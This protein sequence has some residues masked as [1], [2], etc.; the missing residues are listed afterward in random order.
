MA[1]S[2]TDTNRMLNRIRL[3]QVALL[4]AVRAHGTLRAAAAEIGMTQPAATKMLRELEGAL[5]SRLYERAGRSL[6][7]T[8]AGAATL[9]H[10]EALRGGLEALGR[11]LAALREG[12]GGHLAVGSIMAPA[13][14]LLTRALLATQ[15]TV[16]GLTV[17]LAIETSDV[18]LGLLGRGELDVVVGRLVDGYARRDHRLQPLESEALAVVVGPRHRLARKRRVTLP[19]LAGLPWILQPRGSPMRELLDA[20]FRRHAMDL[21]R[22]LVETA[23]ILTTASLIQ[24][25]EHVAVLPAAVAASYARH[26]MLAVL[27]VQLARELEPYGSI[28]RRDRPLSTAAQRF[29]EALH[30]QAAAGRA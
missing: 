5:G 8:P 14:G 23:S 10:F 21:P 4:L 12:G 20:E 1:I 3:R 22:E 29:V 25:S 15:R 27:P 19:D 26:G 2:E 17:T 16:P 6:R 30:A 18:L 7:L 9:A 13:P 24:E 28:V 11:D